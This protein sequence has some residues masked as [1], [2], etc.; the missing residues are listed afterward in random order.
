MIGKILEEN[1]DLITYE[2]LKNTIDS[3]LMYNNSACFAHSE[4]CTYLSLLLASKQNLD[5][6][7]TKQLYLASVFM[8]I[9]NYDSKVKDKIENADDRYFVTSQVSSIFV[10]RIGHLKKASKIIK[11]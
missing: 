5:I 9:G 2:I 11:N 3:I 6:E 4:T 7:K 8:N 1:N 10:D